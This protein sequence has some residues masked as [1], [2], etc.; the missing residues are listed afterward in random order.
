MTPNDAPDTAVLDDT[1]IWR[2]MDLSRFISMLSSQTLWYAKAA[3]LDDDAWEGFC[4]IRVPDIPHDEYGPTLLLHGPSDGKPRTISQARFAAELGYIAAEYFDSAREHLYVNSWCLAD[5][6]MAMWQIYGSA[7]RG[8]A[9]RSSVG[10]FRR[11]GVF[12]ARTEQFAFGRVEY[13]ADLASVAALGIDLQRGPIPMPGLGVWERVLAMAFHKRTCFEYEREWRAALYQ[14]LRPEPGV[15]IEF[16][17]N[18]L[19][20]E[21]V[22]GPRAEPFLAD[23]LD[24]VTGKFGLRK[25]LRRSTLL[26][27]PA[28]A[29]CTTPD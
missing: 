2:Y 26:L 25:K 15:N 12:Q 11:A 14:D 16:D 23:A 17:L 4:R 5:E 24:A 29:S 19:L 21:V 6:S 22:V 3:T 1:P 7:G 13:H 27:P 10:R 9:I 8:V 20:D 18:E 28:R